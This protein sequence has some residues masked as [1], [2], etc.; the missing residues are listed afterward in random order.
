[1]TNN[2]MNLDGLQR[3]ALEKI[4]AGGKEARASVS[5]GV[6]IVR[7]F[8]VRI[9]GTLKVS[10]DYETTP[11]TSIPLIPTIALALKK[12]GVQR[13]GFME[14]LRESMEE[15]LGTEDCTLREVLAAESG[16][17]EFE[18]ELRAKVF[19][20]LPKIPHKGAVTPAL[21]VTPVEPVNGLVR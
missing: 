17:A 1:M 10:E 21:V 7:P 18:A 2:Q 12:M 11:T 16:L 8:T 5:P 6:H 20:Q 14:K 3:L 9:E 13:E 4:T 19:D 15:V